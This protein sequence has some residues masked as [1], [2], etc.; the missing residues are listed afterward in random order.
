MKYSNLPPGTHLPLLLL[1]LML[2]AC[3]ADKGNEGEQNNAGN[4]GSQLSIFLNDTGITTCS[5]YD[6]TTPDDLPCPQDGFPGQDAEFGRDAQAQAGTLVKVGGGRAGFDFTKLDANGD[7]LAD[8][9]V[10]YATTPWSCVQDN[11]T[12]LT[13][14]VKT[15][16]GGLRDANHTYTWY[17]STGVNDGG[18][19]GTANGGT[20]VDSSNCDT[21]KY[22]AAVNAV[23]LCGQTDWRLPQ[24]VE[25]RSLVDHSAFTPAIDTDYFPNTND[26]RETFSTAFW[27][28]SPSAFYVNIA[29]SVD[30]VSGLDYLDTINGKSATRYVRLVREGR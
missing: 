15:T 3:A 24:K 30:F 20:C 2:V 14:E 22:V 17:N 21:E 27:T 1:S 23:G 8:Q 11:H 12:G 26:S 9:T 7:P 5:D 16:D 13:W 4:A 19:P 18:D 29:W 6:Y 28:I 10:D 25:L